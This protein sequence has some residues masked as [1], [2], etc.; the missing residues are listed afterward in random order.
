MSESASGEASSSSSASDKAFSCDYCEK[1]YASQVTKRR[2]ERKEHAEQLD[3][4]CPDCGV[5]FHTRQSMA[6]HHAQQHDGSE[7][8]LT[9]ECGVCG[10]EFTTCEGKDNQYCSRECG[11]KAQQKRVTLECEWCGEEFETTPS[12]A[13]GKRFCGMDCKTDW[14]SDYFTGENHPNY[15]DNTLVKPC[16]HCGEVTETPEYAVEKRDHDR[17]YCSRECFNIWRSENVRGEDHPLYK[18]SEVECETC[19]DPFQKRPAKVAVYDKHFCS[20]G[21]HGEWLAENNVGEE[22]PR[23]NGGTVNYYGPNWRSQRRKVRKRDQY[24]CQEC[25]KTEREL[26]QI[27]SAH[28]KVKIAWFKDNFDAPEWY[29]R[30]NRLENLV[31]LCPEHHGKWEDMPVQPEGW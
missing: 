4:E 7:A 26:G 6:N 5:A 24:R 10:A 18:D 16:A 2:H 11:H 29:E 9:R 23:Y 28:H 3:Y 27:P 21:C 13:D 19:G 31:L 20:R 8:G 15:K 25:G 14:F 12:Q 30:G 17:V 1:R 22:H